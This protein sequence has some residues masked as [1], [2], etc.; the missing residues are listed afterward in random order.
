M[1]GV[2]FAVSNVRLEEDEWEL[3]RVRRKNEEE[4]IEGRTVNKGK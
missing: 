1:G 3:E 4:R 2:R